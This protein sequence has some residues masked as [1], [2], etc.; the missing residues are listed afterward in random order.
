MK[1]LISVFLLSSMLLTFS[2][3]NLSSETNTE[4]PSP[5][6]CEHEWSEATCRAKKTCSK[7]GAAEGELG[8]HS[9]TEATCQSPMKCTVCGN[10]SGNIGEHDYSEA[11]CTKAKICNT[12]GAMYGRPLG[13]DYIEA[14]CTAPK[15]C[16]TC[17]HEIGEPLHDYTEATCTTP[18]I[19]NECGI[20]EGDPLGHK[21][22]YVVAD[23]TCS[24]NGSYTVTCSVCDEILES[25]VI[26]MLDHA[27][28]KY[29]YNGDATATEDG[30]A[31][32]KCPHC[33]YTST[34][35]L[36]G[37]AE[38]IREAFAN[39]KISVL[40]DSI[41]TYKDY[42]DG[43]AAD[44]SNSTIRENLVWNGYYPNGSVFGGTSVNTTWWMRTIN[45]LG[46]DLLVNNSYSGRTVNGAL[47]G[48]YMQLHDDTGENAGETPDIIF[49]YLGTNDVFGT[50]GDAN[51]LNM[52]IVEI[53]GENIYYTPANLA[54]YY[55]ILLYRIQKTYP[56]A[57]IFCLTTLER[58]DVK[59]EQTHDVNKVI[60]DVVSI[61]D[62][63][64]LADIGEESNVKRSDPNYVT[65]MPK[66]TGGKS[67]HPG[68]EG[69]KEISRVLLES[70][71]VNSRYV[72]EKFNDLLNSVN[73]P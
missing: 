55:A 6:V 13:H 67:L 61:F 17:G 30:S 20:E 48:P 32:A 25:R 12:C 39:K 26:P 53:M 46:A 18:R 57:E 36:V 24:L 29:V 27:N 45:A 15:T 44:T 34:K 58:S 19:C 23:P 9:Y 63:V 38:I 66:D 54:E 69:M 68:V 49:I 16:R 71:A 1:K 65:Y 2:S 62:G 37:S 50:I 4:Q 21:L 3:C 22:T 31:T 64:H 8:E 35:T 42:T 11:T 60:S 43:P 72:S 33:D 51:G 7:C 40:G 56:N 10:T 59:I 5:A 47:E 14:T 70:I 28:L 52:E 41:S 73:D